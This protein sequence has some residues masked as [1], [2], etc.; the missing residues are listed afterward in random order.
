MYY[1]CKAQALARMVLSRFPNPFGQ[2]E[3]ANPFSVARVRPRT[4]KGITDLLLLN[5][6]QL[7]SLLIPLRRHY[8]TGPM[9][10]NP[11]RLFSRPE[12]RSLPELTRQITPQTHHILSRHRNSQSRA[13]LFASKRSLLEQLGPIGQPWSMWSMDWLGSPQVH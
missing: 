13:S 2:G 6:L 7:Y 4:S 11:R 5:L 10:Q 12:S 9:H 8:R 3:P 1:N